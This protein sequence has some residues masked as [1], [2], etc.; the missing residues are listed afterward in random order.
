M[1]IGQ[2]IGP[3]LVKNKYCSLPGLGAF[4]LKKQSASIEN[5]SLNPPKY[6]VSFSPVGSIDD[7]FASFIASK[8]NVSISNAS[9]SI[10]AFC[11][12]V[13]AETQKTGKFEIENLGRFS[14]QGGKLI[15][16]QSE[17]VNLGY[18]AIKVPEFKIAE[19]P[20]S[21]TKV[22]YSYTSKPSKPY[23]K[24]S[25]A[26]G[27]IAKIGIPVLLV[28]MLGVGA[29][30][31]YNYLKKNG[32]AANNSK[33]TEEITPTIATVDTTQTNTATD[34]TSSIKDTTA[35]A[36]VTT[37]TTSSANTPATSSTPTPTP[38]PPAAANEYRVVV[39][40][41]DNEASANA[42]ATKLK[43]FNNKANVIQRGTSY[44]VTIDASSASND[45]LKVRDSL[46][47]WFNPKGNVYILK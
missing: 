45:T 16:H 27:N 14:Y 13:K 4:E 39:F 17:D 30:F 37:D 29:Y 18:E 2:Y 28:S 3:F 8:E 34:S 23:Y 6:I 9:N 20:A 26:M 22:D 11:Q 32:S 42:K 1:E 21:D 41:Y 36:V 12:E 25:N 43:S 33:S 47:A 19:P 24:K 10:K 7:T 15:F 31:G 38:A 5:S 35:S 40:S 44:L 46:R